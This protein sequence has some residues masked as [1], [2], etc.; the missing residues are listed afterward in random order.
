MRSKIICYL[1]IVEKANSK[2]GCSMKF[3]LF[4]EIDNK[5]NIELNDI[6]KFKMIKDIRNLIKREIFNLDE[7]ETYILRC[8]Y[9]MYNRSIGSEFTDIANILKC[10]ENRIIAI[11]NKILKKLYTYIFCIN[12]IHEY[13][14]NS[15]YI[16]NRLDLEILINFEKSNII[17]NHDLNKLDD[18]ELYC[19]LKKFRLKMLYSFDEKVI[20]NLTNNDYYKLKNLINIPPKKKFRV[21]K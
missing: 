18:Y 6:D 11:Y 21:I 19:L 1:I 10:S 5:Y 3:D 8:R 9:G 14:N 7:L 12:K 17:Y 2:K 20:N 13:G 4:K 15:I 16:L